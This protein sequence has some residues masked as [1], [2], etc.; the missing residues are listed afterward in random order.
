MSVRSWAGHVVCMAV[1]LLLAPWTRAEPEG[2]SRQVPPLVAVGYDETFDLFNLLD[3]LPD[4]LPGYTSAIYRQDWERRFGLDAQDR[5]ALEEYARFRQRTSPMARDDDDTRP[6][7]ERLFAGSDTRVG[8]P[9]TGYFQNAASFTTAAK[10]A[11]AAQAPGDRE[12]L[13]R[14]YARF[15]P[16]AREL[17]AGMSR[18]SQQQEALTRELAAPEAAAFAA[19]MGAFYGA[20]AAPT[21]QVRFVWWPYTNRTQAKL[22]G[23]TIVLFSPPGVEDDWAPIVL[24]EYAHF[25][26]AGQSVAR[27]QA[28]AAEF[29]RLCPAALTLPNPLNALEE[30]LAIYW[31]QYRFEQAVRG[32]TLPPQSSWYVQPHADRAAKAVAAAFPADQPAPALA[33][34]PLLQA[35]ASVCE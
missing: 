18:F 15:E 1:L 29:A 5:A 26:S 23:G 30:P 27:R 33:V 3:N 8:D 24:H 28:L 22:R 16:R 31:G 14:Y 6:V 12:L 13:R 32:K 34:G 35:A 7:A 10:A 25:L 20:E 4:W 21:F 2:L 19:G 9:Y 17:L 11:I